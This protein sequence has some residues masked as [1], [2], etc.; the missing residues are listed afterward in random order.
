[1]SHTIDIVYDLVDDVYVPAARQP[2]EPSEPLDERLVRVSL[3]L[4]AEQG[5]E[6]LSLRSVARRAGVSHGAPLRHF[7]GLADLRSEVAARGFELL[8]RAMEEAGAQLPVGAGPLARLSA[9]GRAYV[10]TAVR[11]PRLFAL[12]FRPED[13]DAANPR[14][15]RESV[16]AFGQLLRHVRAAQDAGWHARRETG[17]VAASV[18]AAVHGL[19]TLW[20]QGALA[21]A[22]PGASLDDALSTTLELVLGDQRGGQP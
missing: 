11:H 5:A 8:S 3:A 19:A 22:L 12:M 7:R 6:H 16:A 17:Q 21:G 18:W 10:D 15:A 2:R 4:L 1:V 14:L 13:L 9:A 20:S